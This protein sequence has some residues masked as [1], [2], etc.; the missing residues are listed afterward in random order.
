MDEHVYLLHR[1][2]HCLFTL[3]N[4]NKQIYFSYDHIVIHIHVNAMYFFN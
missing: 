1:N 4:K 2:F 3:N